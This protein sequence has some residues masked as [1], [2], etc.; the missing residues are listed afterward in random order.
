MI[1]ALILQSVTLQP[2]PRDVW[3]SV[4]S[5]GSLDRTSTSV[6]FIRDEI[7]T[8]DAHYTLRMTTRHRE[9]P[10]TIMWATSRT[11]KGVREAVARLQTVPFPQ[12][13]LPG[14]P[15]ELV[16]DGVSY[17]VRFYGKYAS[18]IGGPVE[19]HSNVGTPLANW[20]IGTFAVLQPCWTP[21]R[22][23]LGRDRQN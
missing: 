2:L 17:S 11:C 10:P 19:L 22:L 16:V 12:I 7:D 15:L 9:D 1:F 8:A 21:F 5:T 4:S 3:A 14:D 6:A 23:V 13:E 18:Q 20:V